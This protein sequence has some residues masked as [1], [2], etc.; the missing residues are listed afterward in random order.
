MQGTA[1]APAANVAR[2]PGAARRIAVWAVLALVFNAL[3][4]G[5]SWWPLRQLQGMGLHPLWATVFIFTLCAVATGLLYR[6]AW[7]EVLRTPALWVL[8]VA[9]GTT[10]AAFN[11]AVTVGDVVRVVLLFYLMPLWAVLFARWL[12][13][14]RITSGALLRVVLALVGAAVVLGAGKVPGDGAGVNIGAGVPASP[15][16]LGWPVP[17]TLAEWLAVI[18]GA[19]FALNNVML[20]REAHRSASARTLA[21]FL[22]GAVMAFVVAWAAA[23]WAPAQGV[24][25]PPDWAWGWVLLATTLGVF[26]LASNVA[27]QFGASKLPAHTTSIVMLTE[28]LFASASAWWLG[29]SVWDVRL[30]VGG[31]LIVSAAALAAWEHA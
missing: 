21:M 29:A 3:V 15:S 14:E 17:T 4:W 2:V 11:W 1:G 12:L 30:L 28:V 8:V 27:L 6:Q 7:G 18:G 23:R 5:L 9:A 13:K 26:F 24:G 20:R 19:S 22:G 25:M 31:A 16:L 10:N